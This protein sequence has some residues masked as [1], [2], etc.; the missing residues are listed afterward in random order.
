MQTTP[1]RLKL[2]HVTNIQS[3][4]RDEF[5]TLAFHLENEATVIPDVADVWKWNSHLQAVLLR[6]TS[7]QTF[8]IIYL[9]F[10]E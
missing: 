10:A 1:A 3:A 8:V 7:A 6:G 2:P 5:A 9:V 4:A